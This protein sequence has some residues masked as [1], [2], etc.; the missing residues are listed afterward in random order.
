MVTN[1][2]VKQRK[3][4]QIYQSMAG[5]TSIFRK[6]NEKVIVKSEGEKW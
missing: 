3:K 2:S 5:K 4:N 6:K 1:M